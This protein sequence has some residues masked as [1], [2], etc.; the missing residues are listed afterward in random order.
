MQ[1]FVEFAKGLMNRKI[2]FS[3]I[4]MFSKLHIDKLDYFQSITKDGKKVFLKKLC[5][6]R[7]K[8]FITG[9]FCLITATLD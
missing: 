5:L 1:S 2:L 6:K 4:S 7:K 9:L 8:R 3:K